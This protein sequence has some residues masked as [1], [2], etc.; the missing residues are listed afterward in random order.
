LQRFPHPLGG[1]L[2][3]DAAGID[4]GDGGMFDTVMKFCAPRAARRVFATKGVPGFARPAFKVSQTLK[5][6]G[7][8]RLYLIGVDSLKSVIF[9]RLKRGQSI[10]FHRAWT[11]PI[12]SN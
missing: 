4:A 3:I 8:E 5:S 10:K 11:R 12:S 1:V 9:E 2:Q 7:S 6:R